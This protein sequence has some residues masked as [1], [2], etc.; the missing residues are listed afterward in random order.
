[1]NPKPQPH[2]TTAASLLHT[3]TSFEL[4]IADYTK[5]IDL[6]PQALAAYI[7]RGNIYKN[8]GQYDRALDDYTG[9]R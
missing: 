4:A 7:N 8:K 5:A 1:L 2:T 3:S 6:E 9:Q